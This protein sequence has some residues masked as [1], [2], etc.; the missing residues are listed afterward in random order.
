MP[1]SRNR[2]RPFFIRIGLADLDQI[3][4]RI[5]PLAQK[6]DRPMIVGVNVIVYGLFATRSGDLLRLLM[7][8][9][10]NPSTAIFLPNEEGFPDTVS[11][12]TRQTA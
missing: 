7:Q 5:A 10:S 8:S 9:G 12:S 11:S 3:K 1:T 6:A 2:L 4:D